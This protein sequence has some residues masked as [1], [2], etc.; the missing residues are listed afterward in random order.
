MQ[1]CQCKTVTKA[2]QGLLCSLRTVLHLQA[3]LIFGFTWILLA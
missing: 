3:S 1:T 2:K